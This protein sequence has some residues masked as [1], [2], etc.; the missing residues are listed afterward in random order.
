[1]KKL[2][3]INLNDDELSLLKEFIKDG[4]YRT[5]SEVIRRA[6]WEMHERVFPRFKAKKQSEGPKEDM[7]PEKIC[8]SLGGEVFEEN[9]V[10]YCRIQQGAMTTDKPLSTL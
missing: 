9:G 10:E 1:M 2:L 8:A 3:H 7:T 5:K 4:G 6:I